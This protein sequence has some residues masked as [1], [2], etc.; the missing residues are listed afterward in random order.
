[1]LITHSRGKKR[2]TIGKCEFWYHCGL[3]SHYEKIFFFLHKVTSSWT[4]QATGRGPL[5]VTDAAQQYLNY[6]A[7]SKLEPYLVDSSLP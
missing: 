7:S 2:A 6:P 1:M 5:Y 4:S 3:S